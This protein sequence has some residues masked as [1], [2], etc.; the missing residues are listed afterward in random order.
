M[1]LVGAAQV[2]LADDLD[3]GSAAAVEID[4]GVAAGIR[5]AVVDALA[6]VVLHVDA[7]HADSLR[8]TIHHD[9]DVPMLGQRL[10]V[11]RNLIALGKIRIEVVFAGEARHRPDLAIERERGANGQ[12]HGLLGQDGQGARE[13]ETHG[14]NIGIRRRAKAGGTATKYLGGRRQLSVYFQADYRLVAGDVLRC[15]QAHESCRHVSIILMAKRH[16]DGQ[17]PCRWPNAMSM[18][19]RH[20]CTSVRPRQPA[21]FELH[22]VEAAGLQLSHALRSRVADRFNSPQRKRARRVDLERDRLAH[23][24]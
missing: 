1:G 2:R 18:A 15:G 14:A 19:K 10:I 7:R 8:R 21:E 12:L 17:T 11:L 13:A 20:R 23:Q 5:K 4:I 24:R 22:R 16:V 3:E 9:I 6:G